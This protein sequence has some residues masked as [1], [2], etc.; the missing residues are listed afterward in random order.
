MSI[1]LNDVKI[2]AGWK[3]A[4][5]DE[6]LSAYFA[7]IKAKLIAAK[8]AGRVYP[9]SSLIFNAFN[10]TPF[11]SVKAVI[12]GQ[13][14][15]HGENQAMGLSFSVP[16][17]VKVPPSLA[18]IYKELQDDLGIAP[19]NHGDLSSWA[20]QGVLLLNATLSVAAGA[21]NSHANWGWQRFTD[22]A[23]SALSRQK[24]GIVFMLWGR[25]AQA[26]QA[27]IDPTRHLVLKAA[28]PSPLARGAF[29]GS[30]HFSRANA[31]LASVGKS[32]IEWDLNGR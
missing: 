7:Q 1:N 14:P 17:G 3:E 26:K 13:D 30:R 15:Y 16:R 24:S 18:N 32:P 23:I 19:P 28:H 12:L 2:E 20:R 27:L 10:L 25:G 5:K 11:D 6:F 31:Y 4:L 8:A 9:P 29:F 22:A 21:P